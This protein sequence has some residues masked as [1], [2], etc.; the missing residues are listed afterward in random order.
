MD[1]DGKS[2]L[3]FNLGSSSLKF[4]VYQMGARKE[5]EK[6]L[7]SGEAERI[8]IEGGRLWVR[9]GKNSGELEV[10]KEICF[11]DHEDAVRSI[12]DAMDRLG[13]DKDKNKNKKIEKPVAVGHRIVHGGQEHAA[14]AMVDFELI[15]ELK[16]KIPFAP[17]HLPYEIRCMEAVALHYPHLP[18]VACFDTAFH[19]DMPEAARRLPLPA[20][21]WE[22]GI[23]RYGFHGLS[24]EYIISA[25]GEQAEGRVII[26]HLGNGASMA[27]VRNGRPVDTTMGFTPTGGFMMGTRSGDLD[28]GVLL[29]LMAQKGFD[30]GMLDDL[31]NHRAGLLG[32]SGVSPDMKTLLEKREQLPAAKLAVDMFCYQLRKNIGALAAALEGVDTLVFTGGIGEK[33][34][35]VRWQACL[36]LGHLGIRLDAARNDRNEAVISAPDSRC[37]VRVIQAN[38]DL[39][40]ARHT[41][42]LAGS[43]GYG[44]GR[45]SK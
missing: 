3:V 38:E 33:A 25:L 35:P 8:G 34:A 4:S 23:L 27:A 43:A 16:G 17:L 2:V 37:M 18:Q 39:V 5:E 36:G 32:V 30:A 15:N 26:A 11:A 42:G 40:I 14:P 22:A 9:V 29:Y 20:S 10:D 21:F 44:P 31:V 12:F 13:K 28:P 19:R 24:Y 7:V 41:A 45:P 1:L 6:L